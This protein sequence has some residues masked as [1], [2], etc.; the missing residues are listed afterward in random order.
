MI[1][2][3]VLG[4]LACVGFVA[5][6]TISITVRHRR[7]R[8]LADEA[9]LEASIAAASIDQEAGSRRS[10]SSDSRHSGRARGYSA[11][12][13]LPTDA[14]P[15][16]AFDPLPYAPPPLPLPAPHSPSSAFPY[17]VGS[18]V[19]TSMLAP[20]APIVYAYEYSPPRM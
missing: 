1:V 6:V 13:V 3:F 19:D 14:V 20:P 12:A 16:S 17:A 8:Q 11:A 2:G 4:V 10:I 9:L 7:E 5:I 15:S 18:N